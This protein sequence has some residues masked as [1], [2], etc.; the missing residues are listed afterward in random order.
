MSQLS[1]D[2][3]PKAATPAAGATTEP[4]V[5]SDAGPDWRAGRR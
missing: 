1:D 5:A 2:G 3:G 4:F